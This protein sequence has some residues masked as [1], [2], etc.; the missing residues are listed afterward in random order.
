[1]FHC[2]FSRELVFVFSR[3]VGVPCKYTELSV[4][5]D[6]RL[7][8]HFFML[9]ASDTKALSYVTMLFVTLAGWLEV[10]HTDC[11]R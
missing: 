1:M 8:L 5:V 10:Q 11:L 4:T 2:V 6:S 3:T 9:Y 7:K